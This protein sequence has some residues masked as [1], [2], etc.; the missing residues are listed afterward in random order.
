MEPLEH[1]EGMIDYHLFSRDK[2]LYTTLSERGEKII[3][4]ER[5]RFLGEFLTPPNS[6]FKELTASLKRRKERHTRLK[7][8]GLPESIIECEEFLISEIEE[9]LK[10]KDFI[11]FNDKDAID[12][13]RAHDALNAAFRQSKEYKSVLKEIYKYNEEEVSKTFD[14]SNYKK[15]KQFMEWLES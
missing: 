8:L 13:K 6:T 5:I 14:I 11:N 4:E 2:E 1:L 3:E 10:N 15:D 12:Y 7:E 9:K